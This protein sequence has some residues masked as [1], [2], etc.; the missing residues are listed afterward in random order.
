[1]PSTHQLWGK[2]GPYRPA[3][4]VH[5]ASFPWLSGEL[6][7]CSPA[8]RVS[9]RSS[10]WNCACIVCWPVGNFSPTFPGHV[11]QNVEDHW[12]TALERKG[13]GS[14]SLCLY[15]EHTWISNSVTTNILPPPEMYFQRLDHTICIGVPYLPQY[16]CIDKCNILLALNTVNISI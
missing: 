9:M 15:E 2:L 12:P 16:V 10:S 7:T 1:M 8:A 5:M 11:P 14:K 4:E 3:A 6:G 13:F